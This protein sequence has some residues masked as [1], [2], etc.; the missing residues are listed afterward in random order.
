MADISGMVGLRGFGVANYRS[1][2]NEGFVLNDIK[3]V[4]VLIGKNNTGKSNV[5]RAI[6]I[7]KTMAL[8]H[9]NLAWDKQ[10]DSH[11]RK[12]DELSAIVIVPAESVF[13]ETIF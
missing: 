7:L 12:D 4:N 1:F 11:R 13:K 9:A 2:D 10:V 3:R 5:L 8:P 6:R